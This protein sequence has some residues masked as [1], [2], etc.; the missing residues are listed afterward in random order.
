MQQ[1]G[2]IAFSQTSLI[3]LST[4]AV[5]TKYPILASDKQMLYSR[6][7]LGYEINETDV[8]FSLNLHL[9]VVFIPSLELLTHQPVY[10][11]FVVPTFK[12]I[13]QFY[14]AEKAPLEKYV[15]VHLFHTHSCTV[16]D[17]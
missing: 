14:T 8:A 15:D 13:G 4:R 3:I 12:F 16:E 7:S 2:N 17:L 6:E 5:K 1:D 9:H 11:I 10:E